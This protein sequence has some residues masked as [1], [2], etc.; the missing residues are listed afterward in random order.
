V[1]R[2]TK[3]KADERNESIGIKTQNI[4]PWYRRVSKAS[5][6]LG[7]IGGVEIFWSLSPQSQKF[8]YATLMQG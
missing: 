6:I 5:E 8:L 2:R 7:V 1:E 4:A 3:Q